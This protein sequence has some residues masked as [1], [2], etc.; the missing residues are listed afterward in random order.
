MVFTAKEAAISSE[1]FLYLALYI[2][3]FLRSLTYS[4]GEIFVKT[5]TQSSKVIPLHFRVLHV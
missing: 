2:S 4:S 3:L 5:E 1:Y